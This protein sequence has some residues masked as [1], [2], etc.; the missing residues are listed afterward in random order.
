MAMD[1]QHRINLNLK[2]RKA[3]AVR[4][5]NEVC[6]KS[7]LRLHPLFPPVCGRLTFRTPK[8]QQNP[9][10][11]ACQTGAPRKHQILDVQGEGFDLVQ[12]VR[13]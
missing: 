11:R 6:S 1:D 9:G 10:S 3:K 12:G 4:A 13:V 7:A 8:K 2:N 5:S